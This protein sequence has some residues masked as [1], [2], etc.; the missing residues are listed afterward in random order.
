MPPPATCNDAEEDLAARRILAPVLNPDDTYDMV[1]LGR[2]GE[3]R[4]RASADELAAWDYLAANGGGRPLLNARRNYAE[5][6]REHIRRHGGMILTQRHEWRDG[7]QVV[8]R[9]VER[10][11]RRTTTPAPGRIAPR[12]REA[13]RPRAQASRSSA[14]SGDSGDDG[15][16]PPASRLRLVPRPRAV[17]TF[18]CLTA[19]QRGE[20][21]QASEMIVVEARRIAETN[22]DPESTP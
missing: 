14:A 4:E 18:A 13:R 8:S 5:H 11:P 6:C 10:F 2:I 21:A 3:D 19:E 17:L 16:L 15:P 20:G 1:K 9:T 12:P 7:Q 22:P